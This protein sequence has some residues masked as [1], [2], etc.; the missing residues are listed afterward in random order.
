VKKAIAALGAENPEDALALLSRKEK[1][2]SRWRRSA[3][4]FRSW[5]T[6][7]SLPPRPLGIRRFERSRRL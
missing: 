1:L 5:R 4:G 6:T 7:R 3:N 2:G